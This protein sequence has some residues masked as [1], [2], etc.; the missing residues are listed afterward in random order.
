MATDLPGIA[1]VFVLRLNSGLRRDKMPSQV[2]LRRDRS[3]GE[4]HSPPPRSSP[5]DRGRKNLERNYLMVSN[6]PSSLNN[7]QSIAVAEK[8]DWIPDNRAHGAISGMTKRRRSCF[9]LHSAPLCLMTPGSWVLGT[10]YWVL[11]TGPCTLNHRISAIHGQPGPGYKPTV[12]A[13]EEQYG[14]RDILGLCYS[15]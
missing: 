9:P 2:E 4:F 7:L 11:G 1:S 15:A 8:S 10:G 6:D 13:R 14:S 3:H 12:I 5:L